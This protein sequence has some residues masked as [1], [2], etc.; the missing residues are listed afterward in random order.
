MLTY[1]GFT[2]VVLLVVGCFNLSKTASNPRTFAAIS[3]RTPLVGWAGGN[4]FILA[5]KDGGHRWTAQYSGPL[6][7]TSFDFVSQRIGWALGRS[8]LLRTVDGGANW[9]V[10]PQP[11]M[12]LASV[13]FL[14]V[15]V[16]WGVFRVREGF[17]PLDFPPV[18]GQLVSTQDGGRTWTV[19]TNPRRV[20]S[21]CFSDL[22]HGWIGSQIFVLG[23]ADGGRSWSRSFVVPFPGRTTSMALVNSFASARCAGQS[24]WVWFASSAGAGNQDPYIAYQRTTKGWKPMFDEPAFFTSYPPVRVPA[25]PGSYPGPFEAVTSRIAYFVG[26]DFGKYTVVVLDTHDQGKSWKRHTIRGLS[27]GDNLSAS[28]VGTRY[29]WIAGRALARQPN[30]RRGVILSTD[31]GGRSWSRIYTLH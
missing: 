27:L 15:N 26:R 9:S 6:S 31:D 18:E 22:K 30:E 13:D 20:Q 16:G 25:G 19:H 4:G 14:T 29:G 23:T 7:I 17:H 10:L 8:G 3:F 2:F 5:T 28:F 21:L 11:R 1:R 24:V 12:P